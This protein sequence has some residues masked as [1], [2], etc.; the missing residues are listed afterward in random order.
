MGE[1]MDIP[2][3][4]LYKLRKTSVKTLVFFISP[5]CEFF[6][7]MSFV[8]VFVILD[9]WDFLKI[10]VSAC[11]HLAFFKK[12]TFLKMQNGWKMDIPVLTLYK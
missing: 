8:I 7:F 12:R 11:Q 2:V 10:A 4:T 1:Q 9:L 5:N 3:L 6:V